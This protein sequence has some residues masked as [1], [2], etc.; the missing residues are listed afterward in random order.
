MC[1]LS[2]IFSRTGYDGKS[3]KDLNDAIKHRGP[4]GEGFFF[5]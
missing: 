3:I 2:A 5:I 1:G 4:D